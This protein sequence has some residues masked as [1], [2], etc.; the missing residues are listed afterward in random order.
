MLVSELASS[1]EESRDELQVVKR[2]NTALIKVSVSFSLWW[3]WNSLCLLM[4]C[5]VLYLS[6]KHSLKII[7]ILKTDDSW[8]Y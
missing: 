5:I 1:L 7:F 2:K 3:G 6:R 8:M 4:H